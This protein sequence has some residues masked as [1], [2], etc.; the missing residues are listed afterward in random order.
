MSY[1]IELASQVD[2][3]Y[4]HQLDATDSAYEALTPEC[5]LGDYSSL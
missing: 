1:S 5:T 3:F 4:Q 2:N